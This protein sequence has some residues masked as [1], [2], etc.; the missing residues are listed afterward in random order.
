MNLQY[1]QPTAIRDVDGTRLGHWQVQAFRKCE[2]LNQWR[3]AGVLRF[4]GLGAEANEQFVL[5]SVFVESSYRR[6][7]IGTGLFR[8]ADE[9]A[10]TLAGVE[11][12]ETVRWSSDMRPLGIRRDALVQFLQDLGFEVIWGL[13]DA[14][15]ASRSICATDRPDSPR[16]ESDA[17]EGQQSRIPMQ[18]PLVSP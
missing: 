12:S 17:L 15:R 16:I 4:H 10:S 13:D 2:Y 3:L 8:I 14:V 5:D 18:A 9:L 1:A 6:T 11:S 7:G